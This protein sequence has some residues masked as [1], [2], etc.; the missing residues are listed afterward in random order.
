MVRASSL[1]SRLIVNGYLFCNYFRF[2]WIN[3]VFR[4]VLQ[5]VFVI[6]PPSFSTRIPPGCGE[7]IHGGKWLLAQFAAPGCIG[8]QATISE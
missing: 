2:N 7:I 1:P 5:I 3:L 4:F 8:H 6:S